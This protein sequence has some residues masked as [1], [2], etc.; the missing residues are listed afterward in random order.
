MKIA[1]MTVMTVLLALA[2]A[3]GFAVPVPTL[4]QHASAMTVSPDMPAAQGTV[5][6]AK[7]DNGN[8]SIYLV[9][10][11]MA[12]PQKLQ[13]PASVYVAWVR[14]NKDSD[15]VNIGALKVND[16]R[17]GTLKTVT[18]LHAFELFVTAETDGQIQAPTGQRLIWTNRAT[19]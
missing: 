6:F 19:D 15:A 2:P 13:P 11:Y 16:R 10:K 12:E 7:T 4:F 5:K 17:K 1:R 3:T 18:P 14:E 8:T 9:I